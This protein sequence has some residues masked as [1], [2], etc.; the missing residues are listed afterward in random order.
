MY[1]FVADELLENESTGLPA[2]AFEAQETTVEPRSK[3]MLEIGFQRVKVRS[4]SG[5]CEQMFS[6]GDESFCSTGR[7]IDPANELLTWRFD[8]GGKSRE[9]VRA[10]R[11]FVVGCGTTDSSLIRR[12]LAT[13]HFEKDEPLR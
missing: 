3:Q 11:P 4:V 5:Q 6:Q 10:G 1:R 12:K 8:G 9:T 13:E 2:N 7:R